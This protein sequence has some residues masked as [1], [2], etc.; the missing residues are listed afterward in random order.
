MST[1]IEFLLYTNLPDQW[2]FEER[3]KRF[4]AP[5]NLARFVSY[6]GY[7]WAIVRADGVVIAQSRDAD[8][9]ALKREAA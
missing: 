7:Q 3:Y 9:S 5:R 6:L 8:V 4:Y 1:S 2:H